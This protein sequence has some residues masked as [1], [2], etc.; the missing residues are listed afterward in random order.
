MINSINIT[1]GINL[2]TQKRL[3][4]LYKDKISQ[5]Y[6]M[7]FEKIYYDQPVIRQNEIIYEKKFKYKY[8]LDEINFLLKLEG[9]A[10]IHFLV[11]QDSRG[12]L[13]KCEFC[14]KGIIYQLRTNPHKLS[15][16]CAGF[17]RFDD[18][19]RNIITKYNG[20]YCSFHKKMSEQ[21]EEKSRKERIIRE[22]IENDKFYV[23]DLMPDYDRYHNSPSGYVLALKCENGFEQFKDIYKIYLPVIRNIWET[24]ENG[25][26]FVVD[27][28]ETYFTWCSEEQLNNAINKFLNWKNNADI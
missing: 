16:D 4:E 27:K 1:C 2:K 6:D 23:Q 22:K 7:Y 12:H 13:G 8:S 10:S 15:C 3:Y 19:C 5:V 17:C 25:C 21:Q 14:N 9:K 24:N 20:S 11:L 26:Y 18:N 28:N